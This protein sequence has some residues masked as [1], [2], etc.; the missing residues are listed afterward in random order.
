MKR[1]GD[2]EE[3]DWD[4]EEQE[5]Q[6]EKSFLQDTQTQIGMRCPGQPLQQRGEETHQ[7]QA[8]QSNSSILPWNREGGM[9]K[10]VPENLRK[11]VESTSFFQAEGDAAGYGASP[12]STTGFGPTTAI[13]GSPRI[14]SSG[15]ST[16]GF[17]C[18]RLQNVNSMGSSRTSG[19]KSE[20]PSFRLS[21]PQ[22]PLGDLPQS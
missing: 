21:I 17:E 14:F 3:S 10:E 1:L 13:S 6:E 11:L 16:R 19:K 22:L 2:E 20:C 12:D 15:R 8:E 4:S 7:K 18:R 5:V 9:A